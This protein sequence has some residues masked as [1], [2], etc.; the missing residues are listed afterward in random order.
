M[1]PELFVEAVRWFVNAEMGSSY[2]TENL[3]ISMEESFI[4]SDAHIPLIFV[5]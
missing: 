4:E 1:R 5:L 3:L 2:F